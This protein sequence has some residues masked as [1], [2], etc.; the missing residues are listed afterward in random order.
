[1]SWYVSF[2]VLKHTVFS[3][4]DAHR[5]Y[6]KLGLIDPA[7]KQGRRLMGAG[8]SFTGQKIRPFF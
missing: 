1:M 5:V 7:F 3:Q 8:R 6:F 4:L 2:M